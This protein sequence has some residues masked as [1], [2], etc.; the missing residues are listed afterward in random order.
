[1]SLLRIKSSRPNI[2][3]PYLLRQEE[4]CSQLSFK[5]SSFLPVYTKSIVNLDMRKFCK[6]E[7]ILE[8]SMNLIPSPSPSVKIQIKGGKVCLRCK[9]KDITRCCFENKKI[10][11]NAQQCFA[12]TSQAN[13]SPII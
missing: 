2:P 8:G 13:A 4:N 12:F 1:M 3:L 7:K 10:V 9:G 11:D 6:V 5:T